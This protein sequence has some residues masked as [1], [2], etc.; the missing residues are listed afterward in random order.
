[1]ALQSSGAI[2]FAQIAAEY[3]DSAPHS[4][5]EFYRN[6]ANVPGHESINSNVP[7][8]GLIRFGNFYSTFD[9]ELV[10]L[11]N[12]TNVNAQSAFGS[13]IWTGSKRKRIIVPA[14][15][16]VGGVGADALTIPSG[17]GGQLILT[18]RGSIQGFGGAANGGTGGNAINCLQNGN[19]YV[20][21]YG[22]IYAGGGG[23]GAGGSGGSGGTGGQGGT[24]GTGGQGGNGSYTYQSSSYGNTSYYDG[25]YDMRGYECSGQDHRNCNHVTDWGCN[26]SK[27]GGL[28][29]RCGPYYCISRTCS[30]NGEGDVWARCNDCRRTL[31]GSSSGGA[32]GAGGSGGSGGGGGSGGSG[33]AGGRG[34]G[35]NQTL[36]NGSSGTGGTSG[37]G[38]NAGANGSGGSSGSNNSGAGGTGGQGG[39]GGTGGTGGQ[40][41][42]GGN[43]GDWGQS[44]G[45]GASG[46]NGATGNTGAQGNTG[47]TGANGNASNGSGGAAGANGSGGAGG[48]SGT[49]GNSGGNAGYYVVNYS[50]LT[51]FTNYGSGVAAGRT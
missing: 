12:T 29:G 21:N 17:M 51:S 26:V 41:G 6:G 33:G 35:Y 23:G 44:G 15:V 24:G 14:G 37:S 32:G 40:G 1:M 9:E 18:C 50:Y 13:S 25:W 28:G 19:V 39:T 31:T 8:S 43:G 20:E 46:N 48:G 5:S 4:L 38:G 16:I 2:S 3:G 42:T 47:G 45:N 49:G 10:E 36:E 22:S 27:N 11:T 7:T 34:R 30:D